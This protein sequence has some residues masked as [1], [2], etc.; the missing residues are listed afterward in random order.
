MWNTISEWYSHKSCFIQNKLDIAAFFVII[1]YRKSKNRGRYMKI[2]ICDDEQEM[3]EKITAQVHKACLA[4][5]TSHFLSGEALLQVMENEEPDVVLLDIDMPGISGLE[6]ADCMNQHEKKCLLVFVTAHDELVY[7]SLKFHPFAFVRKNYMEKELPEVLIDCEKEL[8]SKEKRFHFRSE[9][10][11]YFVSL[12]DI[13]Y[14][15]AEGNYLSVH[16]DKENHRIRSTMTMVESS[17][18]GDGFLRIH[19]GFLVNQEH[20]KTVMSEEI[21]MENGEKLPVGKA[22]AKDAKNLILKYMRE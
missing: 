7:D 12:S 20:I 5:Q 15:E 6:V 10:G 22:Y 2:F 13:Y 19:K 1:K 8:A 21:L 9:G 16:L 14:F 4:A 17:L 18:Q 3:L 11:D